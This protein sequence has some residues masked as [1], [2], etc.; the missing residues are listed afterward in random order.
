MATQ[1]N[2]HFVPRAYLRAF[3]V[4]EENKSINVYNLDRALGIE[5]AAIKSQCSKDYFYGKDLVI[6]NILRKEEEFYSATLRRIRSNPKVISDID[7]DSIRHFSFLQHCRAE[8]TLRRQFLMITGVIRE[9]YGD[10][11]VP[12]N[13]Q[14]NM[15]DAVRAGMSVFAENI[16]AI[17]DLKVC[18]VS[19]TTKIP[20]ITSDDPSVLTNKWHIM[21][22][23]S[24]RRGF[25]IGTAGALMILPLT[26]TLLAISY[27]GD[28]YS[29]QNTNDSVDISKYSEINLFN[30]LQLIH[31]VSNLYFPLWSDFA[32]IQSMYKEIIHLKPKARYEII[33]AMRDS[34][35]DTHE[36]YRVV[37]K[38][39]PNPGEKGLAHMKAIPAY[40]RKWPS[41]LKFRSNPS[42][43]YKGSRDFPLRKGT[44][45]GKFYDENSY[46]I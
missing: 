42:M 36:R 33:L 34:V 16:H 45:D 30:E 1:K 43:I 13:M 25:G 32:Y 37:T 19:N 6:E 9:A 15:Q 7:A 27:D 12:P 20:F 46:D 41:I 8:A 44:V 11:N 5:N 31:C 2:Q 24:K 3:S 17:D 14:T 39:Q 38:L 18:I 4:E 10:S 28:V 23:L 26:P 21:K 35:S 40:P 22:G 29:I